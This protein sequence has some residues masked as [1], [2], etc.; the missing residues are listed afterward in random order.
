MKSF[1]KKKMYVDLRG[2]CDA[3][4]RELVTATLRGF[5]YLF[6]FFAPWEVGATARELIILQSV[7]CLFFLGISNRKRGKVRRRCLN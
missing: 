7:F 4:L 2:F 3:L 1:E 6:F 5:L